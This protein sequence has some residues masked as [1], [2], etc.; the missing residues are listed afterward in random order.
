M[1]V[2]EAV[3]DTNVLVAGLRSRRGASNR[4]LEL[5]AT[6]QVRMHISVPL[7]LEYEMVLRRQSKV[8]ELSQREI[9]DFIDFICRIGVKH[10]IYFLWRPAL[11]DPNDDMVLEAAVASGMDVVT[12]NEKDFRASSRFGVRVWTP[13]I[14]LRK[15]V[16]VKS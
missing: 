13:G 9:S 15:K 2:P 8:L 5:A 1:N 12:F 6:G 7:V 16:E 14:Y 4:M 10:E 3:F 11:K